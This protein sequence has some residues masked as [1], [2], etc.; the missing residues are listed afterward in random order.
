MSKLNKLLALHQ[1][2]QQII[3]VLLTQRAHL[4]NIGLHVQE[5]CINDLHWID[6][7]PS[8]EDMRFWN[9]YPCITGPPGYIGM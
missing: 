8:S 9:L 3:K 1:Q 2:V 7:L 4:N 6:S 5:L